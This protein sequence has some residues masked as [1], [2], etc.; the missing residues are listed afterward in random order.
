MVMALYNDLEF[1]IIRGLQ[2][3][4]PDNNSPKIKDQIGLS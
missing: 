2:D 3:V 1:N 4:I